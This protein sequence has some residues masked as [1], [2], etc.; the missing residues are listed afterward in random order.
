MTKPTEPQHKVVIVIAKT[1]YRATVNH[2]VIF[3]QQGEC[4]MPKNMHSAGWME[5]VWDVKWD[6]LPEVPEG[7]G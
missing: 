7:L 6:S 2:S 3:N 4:T 5:R 1:P